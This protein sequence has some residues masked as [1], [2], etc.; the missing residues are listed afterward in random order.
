M[1]RLLLLLF[2]SCLAAVSFAQ[3][4]YYWVGGT[5]EANIGTASNW[6]TQLNGTGTSRSTI[7]STDILVVD[8]TNIGGAVLTTGTALIHLNAATTAQ[9]KIINGASVNLVRVAS[10]NG[11]LTIA[12]NTLGE[13]GL[14]ID[15]TSSL[16]LNN[17]SY[18]GN[19]YI[20]FPATSTG[21]IAG[22]FKITQGGSTVTS[23]SPRVTCRTVGGLVFASGATFEYDN[24]LNY[25]FG[26]VGTAVSN[27]SN[28]AVVFQSGANL[29]C[30][31]VYSPFG[32]S[33]TNAIV[34]FRPGSNYYIKKTIAN[35]SVTNAKT[36]GNVFIQNG[37]TLTTDGAAMNKIENFTIDA[38]CNL[39][40]NGST[41]T[42]IPLLGNLVVNG[43]IN[44]TTSGAGNFILSMS[45]SSPQ[46]ISGSG[47]ITVTGF[48]VGD[49]ST[50]TLEKNITVVGSSNVYGTLN[51]GTFQIDGAGSFTSRVGFESTSGTSYTNAANTI[52]DGSY[53]ITIPVSL[54]LSSLTGLEITGPGIQAN[55]NIVS[56]SSGNGQVNLSKP[57]TA[58]SLGAT[59]SFK[60]NTSTLITNNANGLSSTGSIAVSGTVNNNAGTNVIFNAATVNPFTTSNNALGNVT[61]NAAATTNKSI[62]VNGKLTLNNNNKLTIR[63]G[64][65]LTMGAAATFDS[66]LGTNAYVVTS[67]NTSTGDVGKIKLTDVAI[68]TVIPVGT[69]TNYL[70][71]TLSPTTASS[72]EVNVFAG[73]TADGTPNG[74]PLTAAQKLRM[75][76]AVWNVVRT[77]GS[78]NADLTVSWPNALE[79]ADFSVFGNA[80]IGIANYNS[81]VFGTFSGLGNALANTATVNTGNFSAFIVGEANTTLPLT[82]LGF[83]A[84]QNLNTIKLDWRTT[85]ERD[86]K[87]Y[88]LQHKRDGNYE[89]IYTITPNN[90]SGIFNYSFVHAT[91]SAGTNYYRLLA[92]DLDGTTRT[93]DETVKVNLTNAMNVYPNPAIGNSITVSGVVKGDVIKLQNIQGQVITKKEASSN[94]EQIDVQSIAA[95]T[96]LISIENEGKTTSTKKV[97][98]I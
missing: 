20:D 72:F 77:S 31:S 2:F 8:G 76:D 37:A 6:N 96:Y 93:F 60:S 71:V 74:T 67:A 25:P 11:T 41:S 88:V 5:S 51:F 65:V 91:P 47:S 83:T 57:A 24:T 43:N 40:V 23:S 19:V 44:G 4:T 59:I 52:T 34:D 48:V 70:P 15:A 29:I 87:N 12:N 79:G 14:T 84:K 81:G 18:V 97:I 27:S 54:G 16:L 98:K 32:S 90:K 50:V 35:G 89:T 68:N 55:T 38:G 49:H 95:G 66:G 64:D 45:G 10:S 75:V 28:A 63:E 61:F 3:T 78:G 21:S 22:T 17:A 7:S 62:T 73:A 9:L 53:Q 56:Y 42:P 46:T 80:S 69:A 58:S 85:D 82:M 86:L 30:N 36:F 92:V 1:K 33:S 39:N 13:A 94:A 26:S